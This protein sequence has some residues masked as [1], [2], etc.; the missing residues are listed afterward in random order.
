MR[1]PALSVEILTALRQFDS[2]TVS[3]AI[4][5]FRIRD[6]VTGYANMELR[7]QFPQYPPMV[8]YALTCTADSATPGDRRSSR[9]AALLDAIQAAMEPTVLVIKNTGP[10]RLRSCFVGDMFCT[11]LQ[12]MGVVGIVT[13]AGYRDLAGIA[14]RAPDFQLF[15]A[16]PVVSHGH[17]VILDLDVTVTVGGLTVQSGDLLHGD[18]NGLLEIPREIAEAVPQQAEATR[19]AEAEYFDFLNS[20]AFSHEELKRRLTHH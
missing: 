11:A 9:L 12:K 15:A 3:N 13:D 19:R 8:G 18:A 20:D 1:K 6:P 4:E 10:E 7:C 14:Q 2:P 16:G 5:H 17:G